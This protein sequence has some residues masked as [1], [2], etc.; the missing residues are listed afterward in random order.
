[1]SHHWIF[2][3]KDD[4][5]FP[6]NKILE[7]KH[8]EALNIINSLRSLAWFWLTTSQVMTDDMSLGGS[9]SVKHIKQ[10][11][12]WRL[13]FSWCFHDVHISSWASLHFYAKERGPGACPKAGSWKGAQRD[14][15]GLLNWCNWTAELLNWF[16][17]FGKN[18]EKSQENS[19]KLGKR[20]HF[21]S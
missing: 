6:N 8:V 7:L 17:T 18:L 4:Q 5:R 15:P 21:A 14:L 12:N 16:F 1:M 11:M 9:W 19:K 2:A 10:L 13:L 20:A 3:L